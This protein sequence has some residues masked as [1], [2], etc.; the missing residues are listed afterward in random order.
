MVLYRSKKI[1]LFFLVI[2]DQTIEQGI[3]RMNSP[4]SKVLDLPFLVK[5]ACQQ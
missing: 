5:Y 2:I 3:D 1:R 4:L